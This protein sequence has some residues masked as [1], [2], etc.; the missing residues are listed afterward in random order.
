[1]KTIKEKYVKEVVPKMIGE[2]GFK[3]PMAVPRI[4][5]VVVNSGIG[6]VREKKDVAEAVE[7]YLTIIAGQKPSPRQ[8]KKAIASFK[9]RIGMVI[10][11]TATLRG[12]RMFDFLD[13][14]IN[15][16]IP[17]TRDF[18]GIAL[19]S[20]DE[21]GN[22]T[23]GVKEHIIFP[24]MIGEDVKHIFGLEV[25]VVTNARK[26]EEALELFKLLGFPLKKLLNH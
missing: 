1:M 12:E 8:A 21:Q 17:R 23:I 5:K 11:Y 10:G 3:T 14:F 26:R 24:E 16:A 13:R 19:K 22:L 25:T 18:R 2:F 6:K 7:R 15:F 20:L 4:L 9:T